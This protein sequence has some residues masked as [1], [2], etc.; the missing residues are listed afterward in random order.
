MELVVSDYLVPVCMALTVLAL[1]FSA[2][3]RAR[4]MRQQITVFVALTA[5]ALSNLLVFI[6]NA[7][8][9]RP[10]P[11]VDHDLTLLFY[12][13]TDSS[14]PANS[15]A[16]AFGLAAAV[17]GVNRRLGASLMA[18]ALVWGFARV[19]AGVHYP[20]D[21]AAA[22]G[23]GIVMAVIAYKLRDL[24]NPVPVWVIRAARILCLA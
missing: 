7:L 15:V 14:F 21:V 4:R 13:P 11:F 12:R 22:A 8:Y 20:S 5:M 6:V 10:R 1:W 24:L 23:I 18:A 3:D 2:S 17:W 19:Y 16:A 9:F